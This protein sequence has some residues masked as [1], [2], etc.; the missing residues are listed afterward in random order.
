[1]F[2]SRKGKDMHIEDDPKKPT[3]EVGDKVMLIQDSDT[4]WV[5]TK[6]HKESSGAKYDIRPDAP[7]P[8]KS[9]PQ[10]ELTTPV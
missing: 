5:V 7:K 9:V 3:F 4:V 8:L 6:V 10:D 1:L 2:S